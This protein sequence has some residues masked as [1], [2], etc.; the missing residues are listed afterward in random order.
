M[1]R[2]AFHL[3]LNGFERARSP[4]FLSAES[5]VARPR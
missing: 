4:R 5:D 2:L 3:L 1:T